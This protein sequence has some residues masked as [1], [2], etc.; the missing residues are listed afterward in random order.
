[1]RDKENGTKKDEYS[2]AVYSANVVLVTPEW[3][4]WK[5]VGDSHS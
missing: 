3:A 2:H 5:K 4:Y 1:M